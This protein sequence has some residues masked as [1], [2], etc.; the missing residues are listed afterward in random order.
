MSQYAFFVC[1]FV[2]F[3]QLI[4]NKRAPSK[5]HSI[6]TVENEIYQANIEHFVIFAQLYGNIYLHTV[7]HY[8]LGMAFIVDKRF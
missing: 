1:T 2:Y 7:M 3:K 6:K 5:V 4:R 8:I